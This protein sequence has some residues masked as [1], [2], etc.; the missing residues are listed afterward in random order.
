MIINHE[1]KAIRIVNVK[2]ENVAKLIIYLNNPIPFIKEII[3]FYKKNKI[4]I[5]FTTGIYLRGL[6][7]EDCLYESY[8]DLKEAADLSSFQI[9]KEIENIQGVEKVFYSSIRNNVELILK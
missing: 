5:V 1:S 6:K 9:I 3:N 4:Q 8:I 7:L 2:S